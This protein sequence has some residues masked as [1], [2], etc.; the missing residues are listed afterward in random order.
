MQFQV[1]LSHATAPTDDWILA[2]F[3]YSADRVISETLIFRRGRHGGTAPNSRRGNH[4]GIV[5]TITING[6]MFYEI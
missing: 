6:L 5:P 2:H 1:G 4:G 3:P